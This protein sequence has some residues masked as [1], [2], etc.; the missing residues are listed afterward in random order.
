MG[1]P[2][3]GGA[4]VSGCVDS[5]DFVLVSAALLLPS[6]TAFVVPREL[7]AYS[8]VTSGGALRSRG[9]TTQAPGQREPDRCLE[10]RALTIQALVSGANNWSVGE[11]TL[12]IFLVRPYECVT[13][14]QS[15]FE[16]LAQSGTRFEGNF[17]RSGG[18]KYGAHGHL[19]C[20]LHSSDR[21]PVYSWC[22][23]SGI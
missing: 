19:L 21:D 14:W 22:L 16:A 2:L 6:T 4:P 1:A 5:A 11:Q 23:Q 7:D 15:H 18:D 3:S 20:F 9:F 17:F 10:N 8:L 12:E 13:F